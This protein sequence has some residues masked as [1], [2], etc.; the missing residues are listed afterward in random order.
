MTPAEQACRDILRGIDEHPEDWVARC[1][2]LA[3]AVRE[4]GRDQVADRILRDIEADRRIVV[5]RWS[6]GIWGRLMD[7][8]ALGRADRRWVQRVLVGR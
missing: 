8:R 6:Q 2:I 5:A 1:L 4:C 7:R 3:D